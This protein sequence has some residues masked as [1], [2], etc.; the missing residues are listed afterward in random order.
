MTVPSGFRTSKSLPHIPARWMPLRGDPT[1]ARAGAGWHLS[2]FFSHLL[3]S[4]LLLKAGLQLP[5]RRSVWIESELLWH[6]RT[7]PSADSK[8][9]LSSPS[10]CS[11]CHLGN[12]TF[13]WKPFY[14]PPFWCW[15]RGSS[16]ALLAI[17][18]CVQGWCI[19]P[20]LTSAFQFSVSDPYMKTSVG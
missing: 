4:M 5:V 13:S 16:E 7:L 3:G 8:P 9:L 14:I 11:F 10:S 19:G 2:Q 18:A 15:E 17:P 20:M 1:G 6:M 12:F